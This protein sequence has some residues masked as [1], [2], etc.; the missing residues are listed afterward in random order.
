MPSHPQLRRAASEIGAQHGTGVRDAP[1]FVAR[2]PPEGVADAKHGCIPRGS[3]SARFRRGN[4]FDI[5]AAANAIFALQ[6]GNRR[7]KVRQYAR[8]RHCRAVIARR[9][10]AT[11]PAR[12]TSAAGETRR[13]PVPYGNRDVW[14][15]ERQQSL[16]R[17]LTAAGRRT[18]P[19]HIPKGAARPDGKR[20]DAAPLDAERSRLG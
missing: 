9:R 15:A 19:N 5:E 8:R 7:L 16:H 12:I 14:G 6:S 10:D 20:C 2:T 4:T 1:F 11:T 18:V 17:W 13:R 3:T